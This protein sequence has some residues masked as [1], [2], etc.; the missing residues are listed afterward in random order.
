[1]PPPTIS[2]Q[3]KGFA[4]WI[5]F[6][7][8]FSSQERPPVATISYLLSLRTCGSVPALCLLRQSTSKPACFKEAT[9]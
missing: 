1:M 9:I 8:S 3:P 5:I 6:L 7:I 4:V 2:L